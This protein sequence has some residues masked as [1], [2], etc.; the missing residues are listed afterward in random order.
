MT[1]TAILDSPSSPPAPGTTANVL[2]RPPLLFALAIGAGLLLRAILPLDL[3]AFAPRSW[4]GAGL[5]LGALA[6]FGYACLT[7]ARA[8]TP[9]PTWQPTARLVTSGP[10]RRTRNPIYLAMAA[11]HLGI[12][13]LVADAWLL[14]TLAVALPILHF[15]VVRREE[16]Y[17]E[18]RFG[19]EYLAYRARVRRW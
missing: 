9:I 4:L 6:W 16:R 19:E 14:A 7:L 1:V 18:R 5:V 11:C 17:L 10:Y 2:I 15:G 13:F 3:P 8:R 12:A